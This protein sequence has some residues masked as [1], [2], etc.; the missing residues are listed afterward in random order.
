MGKK[1]KSEFH[2]KRAVALLPFTTAQAPSNP[3]VGLGIGSLKG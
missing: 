3:A 1:G 2:R